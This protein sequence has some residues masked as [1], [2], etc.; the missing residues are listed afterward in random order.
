MATQAGVATLKLHHCLHALLALQGFMR[1]QSAI[2]GIGLP[3]V[4]LQ[5]Q[6]ENHSVSLGPGVAAHMGC[7]AFK[8]S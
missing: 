6:H 1:M 3:E 4:A 5:Q 7:P 8:E 2:H